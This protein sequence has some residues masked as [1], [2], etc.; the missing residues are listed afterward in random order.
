MMLHKNSSRAS[1]L[2]LLALTPIVGMTLALQAETVNDYVIEQPQNQ[3]K[4]VKKGNQ[5]AQV[6]V[7]TKKVE[8]KAVKPAAPVQNKAKKDAA[9]K[10]VVVKAK[11]DAT[12]S[13]VVVKKKNP[14]ADE[15]VAIGVIDDDK[16][17]RV[18]NVVE[19]MPKFPGGDA[20]LMSFLKDNI[21]YPAEAE[22]AGKQGRVVVTFVVGKDGAVNNAKVVRSVDEKLD[23]E[24][25]RV[26]NAMP[27][28]QPGKQRGQEV[29]VMYTIPVTFRLATPAE[30]K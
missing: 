1:L 12:V 27:K 23:A 11:K 8:V 16:D 20:G 18:W 9:V 19:Q 15:E 17:D 14:V 2:K 6:K 5:N 4:V 3:T 21:K 29:N 26:V 10:N 22:K 24:A 28:W 25:L 30:K 13:N 7:G